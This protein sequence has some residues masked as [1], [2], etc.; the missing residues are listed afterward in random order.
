MSLLKQLDDH[1]ATVCWSPFPEHKSLLAVGSKGATSFEDQGG[2]LMV[3]DT[4]SKHVGLKPALAGKTRAKSKFGSVSW[5]KYRPST[6]P[7]G[8]IAGGMSDGHVE[9]WDPVQLLKGGDALVGSMKHHKD[10]I[11]CLSFNPHPNMSHVLATGS[12]DFEVKIIDLSDA[13]KPVTCSPSAEEGDKHRGAVICM[14]WNT[15]VDYI[16][17]SSGED[18]ACIIWDLKK[19]KRWC[20]LYA[21]RGSAFVDI[22][23]HPSEGFQILTAVGDDAK[24]VIQIWDLRT[25][26]SA[27]LAE[28]QVFLSCFPP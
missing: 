15:K 5:G 16:L 28:L 23:W 25:S 17:A 11:N 6:H 24:P 12:S 19:N 18:G 10:A 4:S 20:T 1:G 2:E 21:P 8:L 3:Y 22:A 9:L 7:M 26:T 14:G 27:P 13:T